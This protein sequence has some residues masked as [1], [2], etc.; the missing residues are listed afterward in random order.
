MFDMLAF[1]LQY[2]AAIDDVTGNKTASLWQY[3]LSDEE[4]RIAEQLRDTLKVR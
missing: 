3:E 1:A 4:W 2:R